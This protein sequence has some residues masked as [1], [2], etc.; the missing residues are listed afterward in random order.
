MLENSKIQNQ[1]L[2]IQGNEFVETISSNPLGK[3]N[4]MDLAITNYSQTVPRNN[5]DEDLSKLVEVVRILNNMVPIRMPNYNFNINEI[6]GEYYYK[7]DGTLLLVREYDGDIIRDYYAAPKDSQSEHSIARIL[8][9]DKNSGRL[10]SRIE[11]IKRQGSR[12]KTN[13]TI[14]DLKINNKYIIIQLTE[15][16][17]VNNLSEFTDNGKYFQTLFRNPNTYKPVRYLEGRENKNKAFEMV[18]CLF[19]NDGSIV[20]IKRYTNKKEVTIDYTQDSKNI[21]VNTKK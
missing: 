6:N 4:N 14:F 15:D 13:V 20:R 1:N 21:T 3:S 8:E 18:D 11:P 16:G 7:P 9:H 19:G 5:C 12:L 10:R 17:T 2:N